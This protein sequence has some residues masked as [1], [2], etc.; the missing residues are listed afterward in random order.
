M[1]SKQEPGTLQTL[2]P[3]KP[4]FLNSKGDLSE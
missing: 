3:K 1:P 4:P 2:N